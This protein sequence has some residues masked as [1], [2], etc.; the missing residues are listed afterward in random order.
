[1]PVLTAARRAGVAADGVAGVVP[2]EVVNPSDIEE[3]AAILT[4]AHAAGRS[5]LPVGSGS[6]TGWAAPPTS[7]D[8]LLELTG[9]D[10]IVEHTAGDLV[11][12]AEAGVRLDTLA[13]RLAAADQQLA[14][15]PPET[16]ATVGGVLSAN[17]AGPRRLGYGTARDLLIGITVVLA[18]GTIARSGGK[19]VKNVAGYDL[20]KL[21]IGAHGTLGVVV[22]TTWR[23]HPLAPARRAVV[24]DLPAGADVGVL[25]LRLARSTLTPA[26]VEFAGV[27][28]GSGQLVV[29]FE[30]IEESVEA[31]SLHAMELL[32]GGVMCGA[33]PAGFGARPGGPDDLV[34]R[35]AYTPASLP[36]VLAALPPGTP[37]A[38]SACVGVAY[39]ALTDDAAVPALT[40]LRAA[41]AAHDGSAVVLAAPPRLRPGLDHWGPTGDALELMR[42]VKDRFDPEHRLSPGR[43]VGGI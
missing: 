18:D 40:A 21:F 12:R 17:A 24:V 25:A 1:M 7:A 29:L 14:L 31:Q 36:A 6:K 28:G 35:L 26:A 9:L 15:D 39:V 32:G 3:V 10:R 43:F 42:R 41:L 5:V 27:A 34:L 33:V 11:V 30:A 4:E 8:L 2:A 23:L 38:A 16:G 37:M 22:S 13:E 19:V 20:G